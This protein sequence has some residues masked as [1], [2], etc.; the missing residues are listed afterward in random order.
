[1][2]FPVPII[3]SGGPNALTQSSQQPR[4][5]GTNSPVVTAEALRLRVLSDLPVQGLTRKLRSLHLT[6]RISDDRPNLTFQS[7]V[8]P[9][10][11]LSRH[12]QLQFP[13]VLCPQHTQHQLSLPRPHPAWPGSSAP[14]HHAHHAAQ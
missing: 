3:P 5:I 8:P 1:M 7:P 4:E 2:T 13:L 12:P 10:A 11:D 6:P 9:E 14:P